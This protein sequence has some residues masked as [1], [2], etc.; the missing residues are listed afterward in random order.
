MADYK[1]KIKKLLALS[2]SPNE[3]EAQ[4][5]LAKAQQLMAEHKISMAEVEDK[6]Q[7]KAHEHLAGVTYS[8]R[9]DPWI[10]GLAKVIS[11]NYCCE[12]FSYREKGTQTYKL[13]FCGLDEDIEICMIAFKYAT[14]CIRSEIKKRKSKGKLFNYT[15]ELVTSICNGYAYGFIKGLDEAFEEQKRAASHSEANWGLVLSTPPEVK[16]RMS[17]LGLKKTK[18]QSKQAAKLSK[19]DYEAGKKDG[20]DFDITKRVAGE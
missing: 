11:K 6:E 3:H 17:E 15:N 10:L 7:R 5:A 19:S 14:D 16:Q 1:D 2:K 12:S 9:R 20:K 18:F 8:A 4:S 13:C